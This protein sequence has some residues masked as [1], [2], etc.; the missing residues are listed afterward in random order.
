MAANEETVSIDTVKKTL[1]DSLVA[2][3]E[4]ISGETLTALME[5]IAG[6]GGGGAANIFN[7]PVTLA[8]DGGTVTGTTTVTFAEAAA[9]VEAGDYVRVVFDSTAV[10]GGGIGNANL[11]S[12]GND[13]LYF[14]VVVVQGE[15]P[16]C[17]VVG[18]NADGTVAVGSYPL[19]VDAG[20]EG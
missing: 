4:N 8:V 6:G 18:I 19:A 17:F 1:W 10:G 3:G 13:V 15:G 16:V 12:A 9:A 7:I 5:I 14:S 2:I 20:G 11:F